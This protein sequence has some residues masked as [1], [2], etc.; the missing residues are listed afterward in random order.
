MVNNVFNKMPTGQR[1]SYE[2]T[3]GTPYNSAFYSIYGRSIQAQMKYD[4]GK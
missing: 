3:D 1:Y 2:G 4:F